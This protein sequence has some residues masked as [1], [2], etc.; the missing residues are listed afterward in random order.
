MAGPDAAAEG[1]ATLTARLAERYSSGA[2]DYLRYWAPVIRPLGERLVAALPLAG[3]RRV[4]DVATGVGVLAPAIRAAAPRAAVIGVDRSEGMLRVAQRRNEA[5]L[6]LMDAQRLGVRE[7]SVDAVVLAFCLFRLHDPR[8]GLEE[9]R[10][11]LR[12]GGAVG[13]TTWG[14]DQSSAAVDVWNRALDAWGADPQP[15]DIID[16]HADVDTPE[17]VRRLHEAAGLVE[18]HAWT[19]RFEQQWTPEQLLAIRATCGRSRQRFESLAP[20]RRGA[21]LADARARLAA[22]PSEAFSYR[23][24]VVFAVSRRG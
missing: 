24:E 6:A 20:E 12:P 4:L 21:F 23:P 1:S 9:A 11:V 13:S 10:R 3:S 15:D 17:K 8:R 5:A 7:A 19:E 18:V 22:L 16:R 2:E 14:Q